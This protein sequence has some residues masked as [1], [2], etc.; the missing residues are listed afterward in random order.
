[1]VGLGFVEAELENTKL[2]A[3]HSQWF[4]M[5]AGDDIAPLFELGDLAR[6]EMPP[7]VEISL[8]QVMEI[9]QRNYEL[10]RIRRAEAQFLKPIGWTIERSTRKAPPFCRIS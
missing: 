9:V 6:A 7:T 5:M 1:M 4:M 8:E 2:Q 10:I 3:I